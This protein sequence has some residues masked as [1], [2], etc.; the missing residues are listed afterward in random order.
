MLGAEAYAENPKPYTLI[1]TTYHVAFSCVWAE[2]F[3]LQ[4]RRDSSLV[5]LVKGLGLQ[6][7]RVC[8]LLYG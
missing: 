1:L 7:F 8:G 2:G 3:P 4:G 5:W 6:S